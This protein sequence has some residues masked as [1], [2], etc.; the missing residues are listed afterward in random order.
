MKF[1]S[2]K[3]FRKF[4]WFM[5]GLFVFF[6]LMNYVV[7]PAYVN[8]GIRLTVPRVIGVSFEQAART[9]DSA[10]LVPVQA[11]VRPDPTQPAGTVIFQNPAPGSVVKEG[12]RVYLNVSGG[13]ALVT[14][15]LLRGKSTRDANFSL[16]R[17]GLKVGATTY[18][19]SDTFPENTIMDQGIPANSKVARGSAVA[20]TVSRGKAGREISVPSVIGKSL[21]E[22]EKT[23]EA[24]G[25]KVGIVTTQPS[26]DLLPNTVVDQ[27]PRPGEPGKA[28]GEVDLFIVKTE[29][30]KEEVKPPSE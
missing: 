2:S 24:A 8:H 1:L 6:L 29:R 19:F 18:D 21:T 15:P 11:E 22:A 3:K 7:M 28:G 5:G 14:V 25:M 20:I 26:F 17:N 30:P 27:F 16:E 13:E 12:R 9:L 4:L 23:L 10:R